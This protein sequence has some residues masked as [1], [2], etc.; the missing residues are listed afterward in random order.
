MIPLSSLPALNAGLNALCATALAAGYWFIRRK[1]ITAHKSCMCAA[2]VLSALFLTSYLYY[3][4]HHGATPYR[5]TGWTRPVY[6]GILITHTILAVA[7]VPLA[8]VTLYRAL[9]RQFDRHKAIA[10]V[11]WPVWMVVSVT[12]VVIYLMLYGV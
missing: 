10:R 7:I 11:A 2:F 4:F 12:G 5:G 6:F 8:L 9:R 1:N 3:H